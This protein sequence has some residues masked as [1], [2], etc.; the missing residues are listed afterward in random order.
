M[1]VHIRL[2]QAGAAA[3]AG[4]DGVNPSALKIF[5][6]TRVYIEYKIQL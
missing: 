6:L 1:P 3:A 4:G 5:G 2:R